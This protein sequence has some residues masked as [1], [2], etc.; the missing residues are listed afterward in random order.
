MSHFVL[1]VCMNEPEDGDLGKALADLLA[2]YDENIEVPEYKRYE[3]E[4]SAGEHW[5]YKSLKRTAEEVAA[6]D[7]S[8]VKPYK[9]HEFGYS[10]AYD[11][12]RTE[13]EQWAAMELEAE[14]FK[15]FSNPPTWPE[16]I[17]YCN[18]R[19]YPEGETEENRSSLLHYE[20]ETDRAYTWSTYNP[21]SKWDWYSVGGRW[22]N[23][24]ATRTDLTEEQ[25][26][27]LIQGEGSWLSGEQKLEKQ[28]WVDG[29]PKGLLDF[30]YMRSL[31]E[32]EVES[33]WDLFHQVTDGLRYAH[34]W[35]YCRDVLFPE[36]IDTAREFYREQPKLKAVRENSEFSTFFGPCVIEMYGN[37]SHD[38]RK[39]EQLQRKAAQDAVPGYALLTLEG[40]WASAGEMG[41]FGMSSETDEENEAFKK[42]ANNYLENLSDDVLVISV[43]LHI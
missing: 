21:N 13:D 28:N 18:N 24:F 2:P 22:S 4:D 42:F 3:D 19:W 40:N 32:A 43:D 5:L 26:G 17:A 25:A 38:M 33:R 7:R 23:Y 39:L 15:Q 14:Q 41:W 6:G 34:P 16:V 11:T 31:K 30:Q 9:P 36:D 29:G 37:D 27:R 12:K 20:D 8:S 35:A 10:S 1:T